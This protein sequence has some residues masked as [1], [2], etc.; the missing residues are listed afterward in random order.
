MS[1]S[2]RPRFLD[3]STCRQWTVHC[4][5]KSH[6]ILF[7]TV[8]PCVCLNC[9]T[10]WVRASNTKRSW[11]IIPFAGK[12]NHFALFGYDMIFKL[13]EAF[14]PLSRSALINLAAFL[15]SG[16][17]SFGHFPLFTRWYLVICQKF[18]PALQSLAQST[19]SARRLCE[20]RYKA[21]QRW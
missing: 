16:T 15:F 3:L 7:M 18:A 4:R 19:S 2:R 8:R 5:I 11:T 1:A 10:F 21:S 12:T 6:L 17:F 9:F 20:I 14:F 13:R